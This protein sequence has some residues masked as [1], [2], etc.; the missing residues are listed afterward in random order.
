MPTKRP[1]ASL[2]RSV[3]PPQ[4]AFRKKP[5]TSPPPTL[6][7][8]TAVTK[9]TTN[10]HDRPSNSHEG[11]PSPRHTTSSP[12]HP[13][14][15]PVASPSAPTSAS[16]S[17]DHIKITSW[18]V[19]GIQPFLQRKLA[20]TP[21]GQ[22]TASSPPPP[23]STLRA[24]L[25]RQA[26]PALFC[27]QELKC[28]SADLGALQ[29][30]ANSTTN[31]DQSDAGPQYQALTS[32]PR[33]RHHARTAR[34]Y[35]VATLVRRDL[36]ARVDVQTRLPDWDWEGRVLVHEI[37]AARDQQGGDAEGRIKLVVVNAYWVN[38]TDRPW[39][40]PL[41][42]QVEGTRHD[43]K[44]WFHARMLELVSGYERA[45]VPVV[46]VGDVNVARARVDGFPRLREVPV[47]HVRNR[48]DFN[49]RFFEG[50][51][52]MKGVDV[53]R[54]VHG[55]K[56]KFTWHASGRPHGTV[57]DRVDL[58]IAS[59][60]LVGVEGALVDTDIC[61]SAPD[62]MHSDHVPLWVVIDL[63]RL[64]PPSALSASEA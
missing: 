49:E 33:N 60:M 40:N 47:V 41:T 9:T 43:A 62:R 1:L 48:R 16:A 30:A 59:R 32:L 44:L 57:C 45:G 4:S 18:N 38:G 28:T 20:F 34:V 23:P 51:A 26:Y 22:P 39:R 13:Q 31:S 36:L 6:I 2:D 50:D 5:C 7:A 25:H 64:F 11:P 27:L 29:R 8:T 63:T 37:R 56:R 15:P 58:V 24:A 42:G 54:W 55:Q 35:G 12:T 46:L 21:P 14:Q 52:G 3:T 10:V 61:D 19:N 53:F 17:A